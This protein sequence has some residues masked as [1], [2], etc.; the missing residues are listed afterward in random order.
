[1]FTKINAFPNYF[2]AHSSRIYDEIPSLISESNEA[3]GGLE[4]RAIISIYLKLKGK[5]MRIIFHKMATD[6]CISDIPEKPGGEKK[7]ERKINKEAVS[8]Y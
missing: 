1:M 8:I 3:V 4:F 7:K 5:N 6:V 2:Q